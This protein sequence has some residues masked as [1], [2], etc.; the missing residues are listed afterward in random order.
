MLGKFDDSKVSFA[1]GFNDAVFADVLHGLGN[2]L[3]PCR[4]CLLTTTTTATTTTTQLSR[5]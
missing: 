3:C 4:S 5:T 1:D 2:A